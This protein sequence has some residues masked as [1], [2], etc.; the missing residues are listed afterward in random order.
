MSSCLMQSVV[1]KKLRMHFLT[2]AYRCLAHIYNGCLLIFAKDIWLTSIKDIWLPSVKATWL[3]SLK[4]T[5]LI[6]VKDTWLIY[7]K[8]TWFMHIVHHGVSL[9]GTKHYFLKNSQDFVEIKIKIF[10]VTLPDCS[11]QPKL[12]KSWSKVLM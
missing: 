7:V 2:T 9:V 12:I 6:Y 10:L 1:I 3:T 5:W 11:V 4:N 8:D